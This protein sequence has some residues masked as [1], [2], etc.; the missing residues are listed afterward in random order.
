MAGL[1]GIQHIVMLLWSVWKTYSEF[2]FIL[3]Q[4]LIL[5]LNVLLYNWFPVF[6]RG[7]KNS[8][9]IIGRHLALHSII[10][11]CLSNIFHSG[12]S[13]LL[14]LSSERLSPEDEKNKE[15]YLN[16]IFV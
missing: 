3:I 5:D 9:K 2:L 6:A 7:I 1:E 13:K 8:N 4:I 12:W 16:G 14:N 10:V 15:L 11:I